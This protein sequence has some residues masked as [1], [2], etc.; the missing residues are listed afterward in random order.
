MGTMVQACHMPQQSLHNHPSGYHGGWVTLW[1]AEE[2]LDG[3]HQRVDIPA[4]AGTSSRASCR[5]Y[6]KRISAELLVMFPWWANRWRDWNEQINTK[7]WNKDFGLKCPVY[8]ILKTYIQV[9]I[10]FHQWWLVGLCLFKTMSS[11][12]VHLL[13]VLHLWCWAQEIQSVYAGITQGTN[14]E[15]W[16]SHKACCDTWQVSSTSSPTK[17]HG[18][19]SEHKM[20]IKSTGILILIFYSDVFWPACWR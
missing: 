11:V 9:Q 6:W 18:W 4:Y 1:S 17:H 7:T 13:H 20:K 14:S 12:T 15:A 8:F 16:G 2:K 10:D 5:K 3:Q 19:K